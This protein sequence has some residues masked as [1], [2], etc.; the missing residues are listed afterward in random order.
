MSRRILAVT[1]TMPPLVFP[2]SLQI[3]R[4]L[5]GLAALGWQIDVLTVHPD[6]VQGTSDQPFATLYERCYD[7]HYVR[8]GENVVVT[9]LAQRIK[10]R[11]R[12]PANYAEDNFM[13]RGLAKAKHLIEENDYSA[14]VTFAQPWVDHMLG[15][16]V[17]T[18]FPELPWLAHFSD[19]WADNPF[20]D[21]NKPQRLAA[22]RDE[23]AVIS[24]ADAVAFVSQETSALVM[25]KYDTHMA[26]K[27]LVVPH[28]F[29]PELRDALP[30]YPAPPGQMR[31]VYTGSI[32]PG[33]RTPDVVLR[34]IA[35][36]NA[37]PGVR[38]QVSLDFI[39]YAPPEYPAM[40]ETLGLFG[41]VR[42]L[43]ATGYMTALAAASQSSVLLLI[44]AAADVSVFLPSK[45]V[46]YLM[47]DKPILGLTPVKGASA[48]FLRHFGHRVAAPDDEE[49]VYTAL[50]ETF[51]DWQRGTFRSG[52]TVSSGDQ[53]N[54]YSVAEL[55]HQ[56]LLQLSESSREPQ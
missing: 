40:L 33:K 26:R 7:L 24:A 1:W 28:A 46:D 11:L 8:T 30:P 27:S 16:T 19:P 4:L 44:D 48:E 3:S 18:L 54:L 51:L 9:P 43:G 17:K 21:E 41:Q 49:A 36:L 32:Y 15:L 12:P 14:L 2:R 39:G 20:E 31:I 34:A 47:F 52:E 38:N 29:D 35:R 13:R 10:R 50:L 42:F 45:I 22:L 23:A 25:R 37:V 5:K 6:D 56:R 55:F 53:Y